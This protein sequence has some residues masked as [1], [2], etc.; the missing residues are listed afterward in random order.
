MVELAKETVNLEVIFE[1]NELKVT[2]G[3]IPMIHHL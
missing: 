2:L 1:H 3:F